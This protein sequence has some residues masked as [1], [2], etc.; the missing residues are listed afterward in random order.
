[1][2]DINTIKPGMWVV[3]IHGYLIGKEVASQPSCVIA[4]G[5]KIKTKRGRNGFSLYTPDDI[6]AVYETEEDAVNACE[7]A[8]DVR[9]SYQQ[10]I[11]DAQEALNGL[12]KRSWAEQAAAALGVD[13][14]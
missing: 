5:K 14:A 3:H 13:H 4:V 8:T 1:M 10:P 6:V 12:K 7:R 2:I 11:K 9:K